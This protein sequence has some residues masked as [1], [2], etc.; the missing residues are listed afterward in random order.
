[1]D[2]KG[3][4]ALYAET[5]LSRDDFRRMFDHS[6]YDRLGEQLSFCHPAIEEVYQRVSFQRGR[7][8]P[9]EMRK[10]ISEQAAKKS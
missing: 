8:S 2:H 4:Q 3:Y 1:L 10:L 5:L 6:D 9:V 7:V